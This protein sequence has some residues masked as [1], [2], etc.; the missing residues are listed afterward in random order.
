M[1]STTTGDLQIHRK[2][3]VRKDIIACAETWR[4]VSSALAYLPSTVL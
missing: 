3:L 1:T 4:I 2:V